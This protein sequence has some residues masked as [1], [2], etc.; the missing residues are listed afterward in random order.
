[1]NG[2]PAPKLPDYLDRESTQERLEEAARMAL[3]RTEGRSALGKARRGD[4]VLLVAP[5]VPLQDMRPLEAIVA[6]Y[7]EAGVKA[8]VVFEDEIGMSPAGDT[9]RRTTGEEGWKEITWRREVA[10]MLGLDADRPDMLK[11]RDPYTALHNFLEKHREFNKVFAGLGGRSVFR[12]RFGADAGRFTDNWTYIGV[13]D[14]IGRGATF[15]DE[16]V[17]AIEN[18]LYERIHEVESAHIVDPQ[19]TDVRFSVTEEE[20]KQWQQEGNLSGHLYLMPATEVRPTLKAA[21]APRSHFGVPKV[22][23]VIAG[24]ANHM[25]FYPHLE[26]TLEDGFVTSIRGGGRFGDVARDLLSRTAD[27][28]YPHY[29]RAGY[30]FLTEVALGTNPKDFRNRTE[31]FDTVNAYPNLGERKRSGCVHFGIGVHPLS[32]DIVEYA[33]EQGVPHEHAWHIHVYFTTYTAKLRSGEEL[34]L[35]DKGRLTA[36]DD[37]EIRAIAAKYGDPDTLLREDWIPAIPGINI[38]GNYD[39]DFARNPAAW[40]RK[41]QEIYYGGAKDGVPGT[42]FRAM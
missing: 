19:G 34:V 33:K 22:N 30:S 9:L 3:A 7:T 13:D 20:A 42:S 31:L 35:I 2:F 12:S 40:I 1:M 14:L 8:T 5:P 32:D 37:P 29:P 21:N 38:A 4:H 26:A 25:G 27:L 16:I 24:T 23:G 28:R 41:E 18:K 17:A 11:V 10:E 36:L 15:P 39:T 6:A